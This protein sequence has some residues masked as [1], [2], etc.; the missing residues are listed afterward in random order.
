[1]ASSTQTSIGQY[2]RLMRRQLH[3]LIYFIYSAFIQDLALP[4]IFGSFKLESGGNGNLT[5]TDLTP[6]N[7]NLGTL[8]FSSKNK[9]KPSPVMP[10]YILGLEINILVLKLTAETMVNLLNRSDVNVQFGTRLSVL[11]KCFLP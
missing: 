9:Y 3:I 11:K 10:L 4:V 5:T 2:L 6:P 7:D 1:M 8:D